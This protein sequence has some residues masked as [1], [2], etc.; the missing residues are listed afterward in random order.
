VHDPLVFVPAHLDEA[1][2][3][4]DLH[5]RDVVL[6]HEAWSGRSDSSMPLLT[7]SSV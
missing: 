6:R 1:V 7:R 3:D 5:R 2:R 4:D